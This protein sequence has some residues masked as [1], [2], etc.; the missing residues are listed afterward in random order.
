MMSFGHFTKGG[1]VWSPRRRLSLR[2]S[3]ATQNTERER[4]AVGP[5]MRAV[6]GSEQWQPEQTH[7][8]HPL[9]HAIETDRASE[10]ASGVR[11]ASRSSYAD[12]VTVQ[13]LRCPER[14][15]SGR[16]RGDRAGPCAI[17]PLA[18]LRLEWANVAVELACAIQSVLPSCTMPLVPTLSAWAVV[19]VVRRVI[20]K[21]A[22]REVAIILLRF[23]RTQRYMARYLSPRPASSA[24]QPDSFAAAKTALFD[25]LVGTGKIASKSALPEFQY[26]DGF[27]YGR[28]K[29]SVAIRSSQPFKAAS[30]SARARVKSE[31]S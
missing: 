14:A 25:H 19:D 4:V 21:V 5:A 16:V 27:R 28:S 12:D 15:T 29:E 30:V 31:H 1:R 6:A 3:C 11:T 23:Y 24:P 22:A 7:P 18:A 17:V 8:G 13:R 26:S 20:S 2:N 10:C 9:D